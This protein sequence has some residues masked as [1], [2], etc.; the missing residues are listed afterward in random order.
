MRKIM[1]S[2][3]CLLLVLSLATTALAASLDTTDLT[4]N[5]N[6]VVIGSGNDA[7]LKELAR[8]GKTA[9]IAV[10]YAEAEVYVL[11]DNSEIVPHNWEKAGFIQFEVPGAGTYVI[12]NGSVDTLE[13]QLAAGHKTIVLNTGANPLIADRMVEDGTVIHANG[14]G[15]QGTGTG[16]SLTAKGTL[17]IKKINGV[18]SIFLD[19]G[20][21]IT[22]DAQG[23]AAIVP[24]L[25]RSV[26]YGS[27]KVTLLINGQPVTKTYFLVDGER[28]IISKD[29]KLSGNN[30]FASGNEND[31]LPV[32][33]IS[34]DAHDNAH[35][36]GDSGNVVA[37]CNGLFAYYTKVTITAP[38]SSTAQKLAEKVN[39]QDTTVSGVK[40]SEGSTVLTLK[41]SYLNTLNKGTYTL[42]FHFADGGSA[43]AT[44]LIAEKPYVADKTN[45]KTGDP[46]A[47]A[48]LTLFGSV[49]LLSVAWIQKRNCVF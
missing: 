29:G 8:Q 43:A 22:F 17:Q 27:V 45:P 11:K 23:N 46:I 14:K 5:G 41:S 3:L 47:A 21:K 42:T 31:K 6:T 35:V 24:S 18:E 48:V 16:K 39:G 20:D 10:P 40:I 26:G 34:Y 36:K 33:G 32:Y 44:L 7:V 15:I 1:N 25:D 13:E 19:S 49:T 37:R 12:T 4:I 30:V 9:K 28:L 2:V 38:G